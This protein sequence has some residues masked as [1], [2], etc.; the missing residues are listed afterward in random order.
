MNSTNIQGHDTLVKFLSSSST[1]LDLGHGIY[2]LRNIFLTHSLS[3]M[4][5][6]KL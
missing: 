3:D 6:C 2:H 5:V 4:E 1:F